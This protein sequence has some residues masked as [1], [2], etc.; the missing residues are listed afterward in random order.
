MAETRAVYQAVD[1]CLRQC[2]GN[3]GRGGHDSARTATYILYEAREALA[4]FAIDNPTNIVFTYNA[5]DAINMALLSTLGP[6]DRVVTTAMEH[7]AVARPLRYLESIG[8][9]VE[10]IPCDQ[11]SRLDV[12][13]LKSTVK[14][15][16][17]A[18]VMSH[19]SNVNGRIM[20]IHEVEATGSSAWSY[21]YC[22]CCTNSR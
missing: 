1:N 6:G 4:T 22:R 7:N 14:K 10:I 3:P 2:G 20:P 15:G 12:A 16:V 5:T 21:F 19:T 13:Q 11:N 9:T 17:K 18:I 8:V